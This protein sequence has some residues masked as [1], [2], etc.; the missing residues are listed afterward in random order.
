MIEGISIPFDPSGIYGSLGYH[1]YHG[2][3]PVTPV[4]VVT[5]GPARLSRPLKRVAGSPQRASEVI[6]AGRPARNPSN[7]GTRRVGVPEG[8]RP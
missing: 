4:T 8:N 1:G 5:T 7:T 3:E 6:A 2:W